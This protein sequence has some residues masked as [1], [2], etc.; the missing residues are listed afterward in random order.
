VS[1]LL[2]AAEYCD[3]A[4]P[5]HR[6]PC[7]SQWTHVVEV[8]TD[9]VYVFRDTNGC[10]W[11]VARG[12]DSIKDMV[13]SFRLGLSPNGFHSG[14]EADARALSWQ[15]KAA[16]E[17]VLDGVHTKRI[18]FTGHSRGG[19]LACLLASWMFEYWDRIETITF[20]QPRI[21]DAYRA[22]ST[23]HR[24]YLTAYVLAADPVPFLPLSFLGYAPTTQIILQPH[25]RRRVLSGSRFRGGARKVYEVFRFLWTLKRPRHSSAAYLKA[26]RSHLTP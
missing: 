2:Q 15:V 11:V 1:K 4:Y 13:K 8:G 19:A 14:F 25:S 18:V 20:G 12:T 26:V 6:G 3:W 24:S 9:V 22:E 23:E 21:G 16:L 10:A 7:D 5:A 17:Q